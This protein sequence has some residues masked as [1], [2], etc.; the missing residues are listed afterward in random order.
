MTLKRG[1]S[2]EGVFNSFPNVSTR[3]SKTPGPET[4]RKGMQSPSGRVPLNVI[5][6]HS[7]SS[8]HLGIS[9][10]RHPC[11]PT[12]IPASFLAILS[13]LFVIPAS[14]LV[15][16]AKAGIHRT[17]RQVPAFADMCFGCR[18]ALAFGGRDQW[19]RRGPSRE[20]VF[21]SLPNVSTRI[22]KA[23][24]PETFRKGMQSPSGRGEELLGGDCI[25]FPPRFSTGVCGDALTAGARGP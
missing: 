7:P 17:S 20:G 1:P 8:T 25:C 12:A 4:F 5:P 14:S 6:A 18:S 19:T 23:P 11:T 16:P 15:I 9:L 13:L 2:R 10:F 24:G 21:N 3:I 22:S